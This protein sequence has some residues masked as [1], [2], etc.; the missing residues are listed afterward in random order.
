[1]ESFCQNGCS[2]HRIS[3][4]GVRNRLDITRVFG[5]VAEG[6]AEALHRVVDALIEFDESVGRPEASLKF[7]SGDEVAR[8]FEEN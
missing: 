3:R 5:A 2:L 4:P 8:F 6:F 1:M 7:F